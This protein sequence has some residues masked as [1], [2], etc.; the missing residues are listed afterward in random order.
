MP[1]IIA[2]YEHFGLRAEQS[3]PLPQPPVSERLYGRWLADLTRVF[4]ESV[5][6]EWTHDP[7]PGWSFEAWC[8]RADARATGSA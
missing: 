2:P 5:V 6:A 4:G 8:A 1:R 7:P 3:D